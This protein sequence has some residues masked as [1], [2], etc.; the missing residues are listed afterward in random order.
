MGI[1]GERCQKRS[2]V[3]DNSGR[4]YGTSRL[5]IPAAIHLRTPVSLSLLFVALPS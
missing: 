3:G 4:K 1:D 2:D 5:R